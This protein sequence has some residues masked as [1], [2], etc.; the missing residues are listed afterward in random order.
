[1]TTA[2]TN[3]SSAS[4]SGASPTTMTDPTVDSGATDDPT[5]DPTDDEDSCGDECGCAFL[6]DC[7]D[8][9]G[10]VE[11]DPWAQD[12]PV[13]EKCMPWG[14][15]GGAWWNATRCSPVVPN[16]AQIGDACL[17][18]GSGT[19]GIDDCD[20]G[21]MC[22]WVDPATNTGTCVAMCQGSPDDPQCGDP[23]TVC[24]VAV[25]DV[26]VDCL[27]TCDPLLQDCPAN[28]TCVPYEDAF[29]C[30]D[31][32]ESPVPAGQP[33]ATPWDCDAGSLC[34]IADLVPDCVEDACC[35]PFC[36]LE[37]M[38]HDCAPEQIC[39]PFESPPAGLDNVG[40][41]ALP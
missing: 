27:P 12:C 14:N 4:T 15:D 35:T 13:G 23:A 36:D 28:A 19:S 1:M 32:S 6:V 5:D 34:V 21:L 10:A 26:L 41:C 16:P 2:G 33:C 18:E 31:A 3:A 11:C 9:G 38:T 7:L 22:L 24:V 29:V 25:E 30:G 20:L 40:R 8:H 37:S 39:S 17:V